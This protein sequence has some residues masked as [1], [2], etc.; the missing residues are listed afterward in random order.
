MITLLSE[1]K[2]W[3]M[4]KLVLE[5]LDLNVLLLLVVLQLGLLLLE[6]LL[7]INHFLLFARQ[8]PAD[9]RDLCLQLLLKLYDPLLSLL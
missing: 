5:V 6:P 7:N 3:I 2:N 1:I 9:L 4:G 8:L